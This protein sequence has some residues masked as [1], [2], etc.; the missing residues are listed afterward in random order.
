MY[1]SDDDPDQS[2]EQE[3]LIPLFHF[4]DEEIK[5]GTGARVCGGGSRRVNS[6]HHGK[7]VS[8]VETADLCN[9]IG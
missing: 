4:Q 7:L 5:A 9:R 3:K 2:D 1:K 6:M 8:R